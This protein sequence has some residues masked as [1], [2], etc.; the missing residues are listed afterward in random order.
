ML[1]YQRLFRRQDPQ[2]YQML[3]QDVP[4]GGHLSALGLC[5]PLYELRPDLAVIGNHWGMALRLALQA[6]QQGKTVYLH[7]TAFGDAAEAQTY[8]E[9]LSLIAMTRAISCQ[10]ADQML[11]LPHYASLYSIKR[12]GVET[13]LTPLFDVSDSCAI[14]PEQ[15]HVSQKHLSLIEA[16]FRQ[17]Q[18]IWRELDRGLG[19][20]WSKRVITPSKIVHCSFTQ[21]HLALV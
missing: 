2:R 8:D 16:H 20:L 17:E 1:R 5:P 4:Y 13:Y 9:Y 7:L 10:Y 6:V 19:A 15:F 21:P 14:Y 12:G 3:R 11:V 18:V